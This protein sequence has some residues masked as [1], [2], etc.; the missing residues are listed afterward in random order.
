MSDI[1]MLVVLPG[2]ERTEQEYRSLLTQADFQIAA[3]H[4]TASLMS[5]IEATST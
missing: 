5:I 3:I 2:R 4:P 1:N